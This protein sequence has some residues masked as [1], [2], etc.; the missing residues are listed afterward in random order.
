LANGR[1]RII[2]VLDRT[3]PAYLN[4]REDVDPAFYVLF[5]HL[6]EYLGRRYTGIVIVQIWLDPEAAADIT[7]QGPAES[8]ATVLDTLYHSLADAQFDHF[9]PQ[10]QR[11]ITERPGPTEMPELLGDGDR[12]THNVLLLG[13]KLKPFYVAPD[14]GQVYP[15]LA[16]WFR[17]RL[18]LALRQAFF[19]FVNLNTSA[20][21]T[22]FHVLGSTRLDHGT[23]TVDRALADIAREFELLRLITPINLKE[24]WQEFRAGGCTTQPVFRY[25]LI[26]VDPEAELRRLYNLRIDRIEDPTLAYL[27]R[28]KRE[29]LARMLSML[30]DRGRRDFCY[31]SMQVYGTVD[32]CLLDAASALLETTADAAG[33]D[34]D[35]RTVDATDFARHA[36]QEFDFLRRQYPDFHS[37]IV[38]R[39][40]VSGMLVSN[41]K[42]FIE[43]DSR[44]PQRRVRPLIQHEVGTHI[45]TAQ[46]G[47]AQPLQLLSC[48][49]PGYESLQEGL[50]VLAEYLVDGLTAARL[51]LLAGRVV[52]VHCMLAGHSFA[53]CFALLHEEQQFSPHLA[54]RMTMRIYRSGG[55]TKDAIYLR[56]LLELLDYLRQGRD[57]EALLI[58]K[59]RVD[60]IPVVQELIHRRILTEPPLRPRYLVEQTPAFTR[61]MAR[62]RDG[63]TPQDLIDP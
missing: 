29:E 57:L 17:R 25:R 32:D 27:F 15:G 11:E 8:A 51:R 33:P 50:A 30:R 45:L 10:V 43:A 53:E 3:E 38:I 61:K 62:L 31:S 5:A 2:N 34:P 20:R 52:G 23:R 49:V 1:D 37:D 63:A 46:N 56:G 55:L 60:Y 12:K 47:K 36:R 44:I 48:G 22:H 41:G 6:V 19:E 21:V 35:E 58:G 42:L 7:V 54:F 39:E 26:P 24:A 9:Q 18:S 28:D 13:L 4:L 59:I 40:D 14:T 16:R